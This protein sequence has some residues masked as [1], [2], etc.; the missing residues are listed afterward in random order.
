MPLAILSS[1]VVADATVRYLHDPATGAVTLDLVPTARL[2][3]LVS[4]RAALASEFCIDPGREPLPSL[5]SALDPLVHVKRIGDSY[6]GAFSQ[7]NAAFRFAGQRREV[8]GTLTSVITDLADLQAGHWIEH[9]LSWHEGDEAVTI[10]TSFLNDGVEPVT[11]EFLSSFSMR[12]M[13][14]FVT[15]AAPRRLHTHR[16]RFAPGAERRHVAEALEQYH[17]G[18]SWPGAGRFSIGFGQAGAMPLR[19]WVPFV[20]VEDTEAG[21]TWAAQIDRADSWQLEVYLPFR[22]HLQLGGRTWN[23]DLGSRRMLGGSPCLSYLR[24]RRSRRRLRALPALH[25]RVAAPISL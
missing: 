24:G 25:R 9:R 8:D 16:F 19:Q 10:E 20:A 12:G 11:L 15:D 1:W 18:Y 2:G 7:G 17:L 21:I 5:A 13:K 4:R 14:A 3:E 6:S 23:Q 22:W